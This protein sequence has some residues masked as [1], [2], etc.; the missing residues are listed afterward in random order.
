M[1]Y[2]KAG[3]ISGARSGQIGEQ[4]NW[5][6]II[7][8]G[9]MIL[10]FF[11]MIVNRQRDISQKKLASDLLADMD[12]IITGQGVSPGS[13][14]LID[15][16][17]L[18]IAFT[19]DDY[20]IYDVPRMSGNSIVFSPERI[21]GEKLIAWTLDWGMPYRAANFIYLTV[22]DI[23]YFIIDP[24]QSG[25]VDS[26][27]IKDDFPETVDMD[28]VSELPGTLK[29]YDKVRLVYL[30]ASQPSASQLPLPSDDLEEYDDEDVSV[31]YIEATEKGDFDGDAIMHFFRKKGDA[32]IEEGVWVA[33][34]K[35]VVYGAIFSDSRE[36]YMC[37]IQK[38]LKKLEVVTGVYKERTKYLLEGL[39]SGDLCSPYYSTEPFQ[40]II[41]SLQGSSISVGD[42]FASADFI[43]GLNDRTIFASCP[44]IY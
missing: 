17:E 16:A 31:L 12:M 7:V 33:M 43:K 37:N 24:A 2:Q 35:E 26:F 3:M 30:S 1:R 14:K 23:K 20:S 22:P 19:C 18:E 29:G 39:E 32:I 34:K 8:A 5:I 38:A 13:S 6:F 41:D 44:E 9:A 11:V 27:G 28:V 15:M 4:F 10:T 42:I 25:G 21:K 40:A 36:L